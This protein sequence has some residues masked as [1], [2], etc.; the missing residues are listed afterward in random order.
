MTR[1]ISEAM[2]RGLQVLV[3]GGLFDF[4][5]LLNLRHKVY[6]ILFNIGDNP[7]I[8]HHCYF[9]RAHFN[10]GELRQLTIGKNVKINDFVDIDYS[11]G[12]KVG[13]DV[14]IS[15]RVLIETHDHV[16]DMD[17]PKSQWK[18]CRSSLII[19]DDVWIGANVVILEKVTLI[20]ARSIIAA[21]SIVTRNVPPGTI[22]AG[23][24]AKTLQSR[25]R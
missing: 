20:G 12:V 8:G 2:I 1:K 11:G 13:D 19:E 4:P 10:E 22:V 6:R 23:V 21:G 16:V 18:L 7:L 9:K 15:Q 5:P 24:P 25:R 17:V 14:W 3:S